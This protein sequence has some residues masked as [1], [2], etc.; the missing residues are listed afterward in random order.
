MKRVKINDVWKPPFKFDGWGYVWSENRNMAFSIEPW[1][2]QDDNLYKTAVMLGE[3]IEKALN[4][5]NVEKIEG[6]ELRDSVDL[7]VNGINFGCFRGWGAMVGM[8][9]FNLRTKEAAKLQDE[10][11]SNCMSKI[12]K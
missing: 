10:F 2:M 7:Y 6:L 1:V 4:G 5:E 3:T 8:G 9:G 11:I 12:A